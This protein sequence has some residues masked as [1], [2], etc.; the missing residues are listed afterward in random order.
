M[1]DRCRA[2][3]SKQCLRH[4]IFCYVIDSAYI[5]RSSDTHVLWTG[6]AIVVRA[7]VTADPKTRIVITGQGIASVFGNDVNTFYDRCAHPPQC[8]VQK[9][10]HSCCS[11]G[12]GCITVWKT[13]GRLL[14]DALTPRCAC[15]L[16]EGKSGVKPIS[17]FD[18]SDFPTTFAAQIENF[19]NEGCEQ[20]PFM[21]ELCSCK[22][23]TS[24][25]C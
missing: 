20:T 10:C 21:K 16:L 18:A 25:A 23:K 13:H 6:L 9:W 8:H 2:S 12:T 14:D 19:D 5:G 3:D 11:P 15:S 1:S 7:A 17:R 22:K 24:N 4:T